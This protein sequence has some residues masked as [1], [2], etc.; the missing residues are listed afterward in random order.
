M[1]YEKRGRTAC[2]VKEKEVNERRRRKVGEVDDLLQL[3]TLID[4]LTQKVKD[5]EE[6]EEDESVPFVLFP[7]DFSTR[8]L[9]KADSST[10]FRKEN[11]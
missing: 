6:E 4:Y 3:Q 8:P 9:Q 10:C 7:C 1:S 5:E 11:V 2:F